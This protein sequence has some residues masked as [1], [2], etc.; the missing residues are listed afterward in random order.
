MPMFLVTIS[1]SGPEFDRSKPLQEQSGWAEHA[2]FMD[3]LVDQGFVILGGPLPGHRVA[4]AI[5]SS[6][7]E[8]L[9]ATL[10][11]DNWSGSHL[12]VERVEPWD[13]K[14]DGRRR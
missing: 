5:E 14:L 11:R 9:R 13:V 2:A 3:S 10:A 7:E 4:H 12:V 1:Q 8:A 6:S